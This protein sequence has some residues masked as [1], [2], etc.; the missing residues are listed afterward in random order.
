MVNNGEDA[1]PAYTITLQGLQKRREL[2]RR[3][4]NHGEDGQVAN[5]LIDLKSV[6]KGNFDFDSAID[7]ACELAGNSG[8]FLMSEEL[9]QPDSR[10]TISTGDRYAADAD[11]G[12]N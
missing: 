5:S 4:S 3:Y 12:E 10:L 8:A 11:P 1:L 2:E 9:P 7:Q 6:I